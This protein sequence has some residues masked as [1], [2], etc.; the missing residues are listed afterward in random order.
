MDLPSFQKFD[1]N[2]WGM[3]LLWIFAKQ[4]HVM[5]FFMKLGQS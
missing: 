2:D 1:L 4:M 3:R 5:I